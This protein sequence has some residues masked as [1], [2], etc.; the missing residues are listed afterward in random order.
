MHCF[1]MDPSDIIS[2]RIPK[3]DRYER[4][5]YCF[6]CGRNCRCCYFQK[7][8][9][10]ISYGR[11]YHRRNS[12]SIFAYLRCLAD[13][14]NRLIQIMN[15][16]LMFLETAGLTILT[17]TPVMYLG[18]C[19]DVKKVGF[20]SFFIY[21][22]LVNAITNIS[23]NVLLL[24]ARSPG[25]VGHFAYVCFL[26]VLEVIVYLTECFMYRFAFAGKVSNKR[27]YVVVFIAN[28]VSFMTGLLIY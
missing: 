27:I 20:I 22:F 15:I 25:Y 7:E 21:C 23:L 16:F 9:N 12:S 14:G 8:K 6:V 3:E 4:F 24:A 18:F 2:L 19:K 1:S 10:D 13:V 5:I 28:A 11:L 17:E 26:A